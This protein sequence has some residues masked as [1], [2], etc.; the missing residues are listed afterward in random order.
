ML[1]CSILYQTLTQA[2]MHPCLYQTTGACD[3]FHGDVGFLNNHV[4]FG[5]FL[6]QSL[7]LVNPAVALHYMDYTKYF[8]DEAYKP[9]LDNQLDGGAWTEMLTSKYFGANDPYSG[10]IID[11]RWANTEMPAVTD[12]FY[13]DN[14]IDSDGEAFF[15]GEL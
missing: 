5:L 6:E 11:G 9:H 12:Q 10:H 13:A 3:E 14:G 7:Q 1:Q 15:P 2:K 8:T 4:F